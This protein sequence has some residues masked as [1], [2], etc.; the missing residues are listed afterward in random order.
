MSRIESCAH[1][2]KCHF[3]VTSGIVLGHLVSSNGIEV[4]KSKTELTSNLPTPNNVKEVRFVIGQ[5]GFYKRCIKDLSVISRPLCN[6]PSKD[7][8]FEC[9][10]SCQEAF[11]KVKNMLISTPMIQPPY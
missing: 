8:S 1:L 9:T 4:D 2:G 3:V 7:T 6:I 10:K 5:A 11:V